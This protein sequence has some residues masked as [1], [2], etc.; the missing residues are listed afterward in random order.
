MFYALAAPLSGGPGA[1]SSK[2][3]LLTTS[4]GTASRSLTT[5][6]PDVPVLKGQRPAKAAGGT[7]KA[8]ACPRPLATSARVL[9]DGYIRPALYDEK[10]PIPRCGAY[11]Y[12]H[13]AGTFPW[14]LSAERQRVPMDDLDVHAGGASAGPAE[15]LLPLAARR[16][17]AHTLN[18]HIARGALGAAAMDGICD[19]AA[20]VLPRVAALLSGA[21]DGSA[22]AAAE[23]ERIFTPPLLARYTRD[24]GRLRADSVQLA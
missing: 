17:L 14:L 18:M 16:R 12:T 2:W 8:A 11:S 7:L 5:K 15:Q 20:A 24:L 21:S 3:A 9:P 10:T 6:K 4:I 19:G 13:H 1:I 23:L 22:G